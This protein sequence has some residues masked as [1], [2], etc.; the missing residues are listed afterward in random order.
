MGRGGVKHIEF[1][2]EGGVGGCLVVEVEEGGRGRGGGGGRVREGRG[3]KRDGGLDSEKG[4]TEK[5]C[6]IIGL[7]G[8]EFC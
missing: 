3:G 7:N 1:E 8:A 2:K 6:P 5:T 4:A